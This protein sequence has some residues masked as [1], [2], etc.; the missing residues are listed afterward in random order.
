[1]QFLGQLQFL[2]TFLYRVSSTGIVYRN[3][4][5]AGRVR[6]AGLP[7]NYFI[8]GS[9]RLGVSRNFD[10]DCESHVT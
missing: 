5:P 7:T 8:R 1:M 4:Q 9:E 2:I 3:R 6:Q 10:T